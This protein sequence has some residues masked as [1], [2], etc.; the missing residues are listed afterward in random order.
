MALSSTADLPSEE[1][2]EDTTDLEALGQDLEEMRRA[3]GAITVAKRRP[4][5][6]G[7]YEPPSSSEPSKPATPVG[8]GSP[9]PSGLHSSPSGPTSKS[10]GT[11]ANIGSP[12][13]SFCR[14]HADV[15]LCR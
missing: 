12:R 2:Q 6:A 3:S 7:G 13:V 10:S 4:G 11:W 8:V 5:D 15:C 9:A 1:E 14:R